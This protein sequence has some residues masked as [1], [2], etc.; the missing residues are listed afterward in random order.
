MTSPRSPRFFLLQRVWHVSIP[1]TPVVYNKNSENYELN[2]IISRQ[3][4]CLLLH[5][6]FT[7]ERSKQSSL[8]FRQQQFPTGKSIN[9]HVRI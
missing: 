8:K 5:N 4:K 1:C 6:S 2:F 3:C 7:P 9:K